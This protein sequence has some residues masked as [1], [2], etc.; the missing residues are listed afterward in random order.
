MVSATF[1][2]MP[3]TRRQTDRQAENVDVRPCVHVATISLA[4]PFLKVTFD[5]GLRN[6]ARIFVSFRGVLFARSIN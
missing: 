2:V 6:V 1:D 4:K 5:V 3:G